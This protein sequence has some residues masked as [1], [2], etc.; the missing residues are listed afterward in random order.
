MQLPYETVDV[1]TNTRFGGNQLAVVADARGL[2]KEQM[3][4]I[5]CEFRYSETTFVTPPS[6]PSNTARVRIFTP[7][8]EVPFAGHPNVGTAFTLGRL[9]ALFDKQISDVMQFEEGAGLVEV[10]IIRD[11]SDIVGASIRAPQA[12]AI[13]KEVSAETIASCLSTLPHDIIADRHK[14]VIASVGLPFAIA[15][16]WSVEALAKARPNFAAF[17]E[18]KERYRGPDERFSLFVYCRSSAGEGKLRARMFA[19][20]AGVLE[21]PATG[22]AS[23]A[24]AGLLSSL[25]PRSD[26]TLQF[27]IEQGIEMGRPSTIQV[28]SQKQAGTVRLIEVSGRCVQVMRGTI[29]L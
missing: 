15:E 13:G 19:P 14:P 26:A 9:G 4:A 12:L 10:R 22:S 2:A 16:V 5:A 27:T 25:D 8:N 6:D 7:A 29:E 17:Y 23:A 18:A 28:M 1:F 11:G 24:L 20:L 3:Q 21:D